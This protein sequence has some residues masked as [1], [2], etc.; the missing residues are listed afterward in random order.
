MFECRVE[1]VEKQLLPYCGMPVCLLMKDGRRIVG[2][3]TSC[4]KGALILNGD[5]RSESAAA[6]SSRS[7]AGRRAK[8]TRIQSRNRKPQTTANVPYVPVEPLAPFGSLS[9]GPLAWE[10][11]KSNQV[12][13]RAIESVLIL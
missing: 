12:P 7:T 5:G 8:R 10:T 2:R 3:M 1:P 9:L 11:A 4:R 6:A 13:L